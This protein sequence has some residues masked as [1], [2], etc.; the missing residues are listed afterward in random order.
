MRAGRLARVV[1]VGNVVVLALALAVVVTEVDGSARV[2]PEDEPGRASPGPVLGEGSA[3][4]PATGAAEG[5][6]VDPDARLVDLPQHELSQLPAVPRTGVL[7]GDPGLD[8]GCAWVEMDGAPH[9]V[10]WPAGYRAAFGLAEDAGTFELVDEAGRVVAR[11]GAPIWFTGARSG[12][13]ERLDRCHVGADHV[14]YV[15]AVGTDVP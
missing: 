9:A 4:L 1:G 12:G 3:V 2:V 8:G 11:G 6:P 7:G 10:L 13:A 5:D 15:G 14:W